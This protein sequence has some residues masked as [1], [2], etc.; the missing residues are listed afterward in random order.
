MTMAWEDKSLPKKERLKAL[1]KEFH[2]EINGIALT[3]LGLTGVGVGSY[4]LGRINEA[5]AS[6]ITNV[7]TR[8]QPH[9]GNVLLVIRI[10][11]GNKTEEGW[12]Q[13]LY[14]DFPERMA[15]LFAEVRSQK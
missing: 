8:M 15:D 3:I 11:K 4:W 14:E 2:Q 5:N 13:D 10:I 12:V 1:Y 7:I 9:D 6:R